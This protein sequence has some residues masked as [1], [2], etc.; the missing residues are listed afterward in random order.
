MMVVTKDS[1]LQP[2]GRRARNPTVRGRQAARQAAKG[3][4]NAVASKVASE[5][6]I[7]SNPARLLEISSIFDQ[8]MEK[9]AIDAGVEMVHRLRTGSRR[10]Q[11]TVEMMLREAGASGRAFEKP[12]N[13]W[14]RT[15]KEI[16]RAAG[17]VRDLDVHRKLLEKSVD[18]PSLPEEE[19]LKNQAEK[20][21]QR[22]KDERNAWAEALQKKITKRHE[23]MKQLQAAFLA[24]ANHAHSRSLRRRRPVSAVALEDFVRI[25]D[26]MPLLDP[27][28]LHDFRKAT[29]KARYVAELGGED[30]SSQAVAKALKRVQ[31]AIGEW[32]DW[33]CLA[34][35]ANTALGR[36]GLELIAWLES[37][38]DHFLA[39]ALSI[40]LRVRGQL[41]GEWEAAKGGAQS[42]KFPA[43]V[44]SNAPAQKA[45]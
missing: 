40:T 26:R 8:T 43:R 36:D 4:A 44:T 39:E 2:P 16:R 21:D 38:A 30:G 1:S 28:N 6:V 29:K 17:R 32:H 34:E 15:I 24:A 25:V 5:T 33:R 35:E 13:A 14:L 9:C 19:R 31:D 3:G 23:K 10:V 37:Q 22:L 27:D 45:S 12:A 42:R 11:A 20:L 18:K 41:L 7:A